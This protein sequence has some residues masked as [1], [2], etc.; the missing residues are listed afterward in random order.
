MVIC[1]EIKLHSVSKFLAI[2]NDV[3]ENLLTKVITLT[4]YFPMIASEWATQYEWL[5]GHM[6]Y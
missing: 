1:E 6:W 5:N 3:D 4:T 2:T